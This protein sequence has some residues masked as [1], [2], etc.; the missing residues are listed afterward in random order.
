MVSGPAYAQGEG[1]L[2]GQVVARADGTST[3][4]AVVRLEGTALIE[5]LENRTAADGRFAF[6]RLVPGE[7]LL[8]VH[9]ENFQPEQ[10]R[11]TLRPR[12]I[13]STTVEL[14]LRPF[15]QTVEVST[16]PGRISTTHSP[17]STLIS[18][19]RIE[20][21]PL[22][23]RSNL[24]DV[25]VTAAPGMIRGHDDFVHI[26]G[27]EVALN[28][29]IN[30]V[31][32]WENAH[33]LFSSG[34]GADYINSINVM[35]GGFSAEYGNRFGGVLDIVTKSGFT[36][37][38]H[39]SLTV[40][41]GTALRH[42]AS[43]EYGGHTSRTGYYVNFGGFESAR[44]LSPPDPRSIHNTGRGARG[45]AQFDFIASR[46]DYL[47]LV[48]MADG[49]NFQLPKTSQ[50]EEL[51]PHLNS[52]QR[53]RSQS[54]IFS[55]DR[56]YSNGVLQ[57]AFY[58]KG[59]RSRL[60]PNGD[61][62]GAKADTERK[63]S[64]FGIKSD[65]TRFSGRHAFKGGVDLVLLRPDEEL[66]YLSQPWIDYTHVIG[67][68]HIHFRG[69]NQG[70]GVPRPVVFNQK[71]TGGQISLYLQDKI[72][73]TRGLS[74]DVGLRYDQYSLAV[75]AVH[76]SPRVNLAYQLRSGTVF[77]GSYNHFFVPPPIENVL[78]NSAGLTGWISEIGV[79]LPPLR[80][81]VEDQVE[82]GVMQPLA[83]AL[84]VGVTGYYRLSDNPVHTVLFPDV[85][86]YGYA[87][88]DKGKAYGMEL[89]M[90]VP[91][92]T[93]TGLSSYFNYA[94][95]RVYFF[96]PITAGFTTE[97]AHISERNRFLAPMDQTHTLTSGV[98]YRHA[99]SRLWGSV[100][101]EYGSGTPTGHGAGDHEHEAGEADHSE[102]DAAAIGPRVPRHFTQNL[103][104]G[105][106]ALTNG[107]RT[108]VGFQ[109]NVENLSNNLYVV[110]RESAFTPGQYSLPRQFS[111]SVKIRF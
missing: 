79:P 78:M 5:P 109:F 31:S 86:V 111:G 7:Y 39:G 14:M 98:T 77:H 10:Y 59:S 89:K 22:P 105:W 103:T 60:L 99:P 42:N 55:W 90:E 11:V 20:T 107:E 56:V 26:R 84:R 102:G 106:D 87:N 52:F 73:V 24:T 70:S 104:I 35:T 23:Q 13:Q 66:Y 97:A 110:A 95:G 57:T 21:L 58:Q 8:S 101:F 76:F 53:T 37:D 74:A 9:H 12:E 62:Y 72:Q 36:M 40:G 50:D 68:G 44:F 94:L 96:N 88:F 63:L 92:L 27:S 28:P 47:K 65:L 38:N 19:E 32:F 49:T 34:L 16:D 43:V 69:P 71:N 2:Y 3:P 33:S 100:V 25:I 1:A 4:G 6:S 85:R 82:L 18:S 83:K 64:T 61:V 75:S 30:G 93:N 41:A 17:G 48:L 45:F 80:P 46:R 108:G 15:A 81:I 54:L 29:F 91:A 51:R 67:Q